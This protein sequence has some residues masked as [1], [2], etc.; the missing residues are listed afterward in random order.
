MIELGALVLVAVAV[1][2]LVFAAGVIVKTLLWLVFLPFRLVFWLIGSL[3]I[4]PFLLLKL[5]AG[6]VFLIAL[7]ILAIAFGVVTVAVLIPA[8]PLLLLI[9]LVWYLARPEARVAVRG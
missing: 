7:P 9:A 6:A 8:I 3:L 5:V 2:G 1:L 4:L